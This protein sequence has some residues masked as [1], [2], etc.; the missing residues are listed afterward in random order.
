VNDKLL[1]E[2]QAYAGQYAQQTI[3]AHLAAIREFEAFIEGVSF[4][5]LAKTLVDRYR[6]D[7]LGRGA[8]SLGA[9]ALSLS[10]IRHKASHVAAFLTWLLMQEGHRRLPADL[11]EYLKLP[12]SLHAKTIEPAPKEYPDIERAIQMVQGMSSSTVAAQRD[13]AIVA[14][15]FVSGLRAGALN[16]LRLKHVD[17]AQRTVLQNA[18]EMKAK[19]GKSYEAAWFMGTEPL[20][21]IVVAWIETLQSYGFEAEDAVFPA[22][23]YLAHQ[24]SSTT[25]GRARIPAPKSEGAITKAFAIASAIS[26]AN[27]TPHSA[28][29]C[30]KALGDKLCT[31]HAQR[32][33]W[34]LNLGHASQV[35]SETHYG[36]M[37]DQE[38]RDVLAGV[39]S[40]PVLSQDE[41]DLCLDYY[42]HRLMPGSL[43]F[44]RAKT[45][46]EERRRAKDAEAVVE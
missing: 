27:Y 19:N 40:T 12:K 3:D 8:P 30:L 31:S 41:K 4:A 14:M 16:T 15:A 10:S 38:R 22:V 7:L 25:S 21:E 43:E 29:H 46:I 5:K 36:K 18:R 6:A 44:K 20:Q 2:W 26:G 37:T 13:R 9:A 34:S 17:C 39:G 32:K 23:A 1:Y 45:L 33:A 35:T 11:A 28:R 24:S 42:D